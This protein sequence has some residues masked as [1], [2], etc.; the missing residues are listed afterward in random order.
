V[1]KVY[2]DWDRT[3]CLCGE[4]LPHISAAVCVAEDGRIDLILLDPALIGDPA[5]T[6]DHTTQQ[7]P[8]EQPGL[9]PPRWRDR[10]QLAPLRCGRRTKSGASC[11]ACVGQPGE[12]CGWHRTEARQ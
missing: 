6:Y 12:A 4:G 1:S 7:A 5:H 9:L 8:H 3:V 11:R 10:V 2:I